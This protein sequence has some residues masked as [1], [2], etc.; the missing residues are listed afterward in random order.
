ML[1]KLEI[2]HGVSN[3]LYWQRLNQYIILQ[4]VKNIEN[5]KSKIY[6]ISQKNC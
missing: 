5:I 2:R 3:K 6:E 4:R 1:P